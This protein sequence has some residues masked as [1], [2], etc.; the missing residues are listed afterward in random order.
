MGNREALVNSVWKLF[1]SLQYMCETYDALN[2]RNYRLIRTKNDFYKINLELQIFDGEWIPIELMIEA[3]EAD[4]LYKFSSEK[5]H[6]YSFLGGN[7][8]LKMADFF[9][10][11]K[12]QSHI[13]ICSEAFCSMVKEHTLLRNSPNITC[14]SINRFKYLEKT[15]LNG[16]FF[17]SEKNCF[18]KLVQFFSILGCTAHSQHGNDKLSVANLIVLGWNYAPDSYERYL[19]L[20]LTSQGFLYNYLYLSGINV[21]EPVPSFLHNTCRLHSILLALMRNL[22]AGTSIRKHQVDCVFITLENITNNQKITNIS[23]AISLGRLVLDFLF[24]K[25]HPDLGEDVSHIVRLLFFVLD[26]ISRNILHNVLRKLHI[27]VCNIKHSLGSPMRFHTFISHLTG[28]PV[29]KI[30]KCCYKQ[31]TEY[32]KSGSESFI[33]DILP[34]KICSKNAT[35]LSLQ[36]SAIFS[37]AEYFSQ[38]KS[39]QFNFEKIINFPCPKSL[40]LCILSPSSFY[41][42]KEEISCNEDK[43]KCH[44]FNEKNLMTDLKIEVHR[45][46]SMQRSAEGRKLISKIEH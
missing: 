20:T 10:R 12:D 28:I 13:K 21:L 34:K 46:G 39:N 26:L 6:F 9:D 43:I 31:R 38:L 36:D 23:T 22:W 40:K 11:N 44:E 33:R 17:E 24:Q 19:P 3:E 5:L 41:E 42:E 1:E 45:W 27:K 7:Q 25:T 14:S 16:W 32:D 15:R 4:A 29:K 2:G 37:A 8:M 30:K 18:R 35:V